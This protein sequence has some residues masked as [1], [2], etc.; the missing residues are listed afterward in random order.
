VGTGSATE[1]GGGPRFGTM[2]ALGAARRKPL[3]ARWAILADAGRVSTD[4]VVRA[5]RLKGRGIRGEKEGRSRSS[6]E[7]AAS[8]L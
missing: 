1:P 2:P 3:P 8:P 6:P 5:N 7:M 4:L